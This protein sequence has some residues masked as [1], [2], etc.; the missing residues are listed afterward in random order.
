MC[1]DG[2]LIQ[3]HITKVTKMLKYRYSNSY[4]L[5]YI[6]MICRDLEMNSNV[7]HNKIIKKNIYKIYLNHQGLQVQ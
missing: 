3:V 4:I 2:C 5:E 7:N 6:G 1:C